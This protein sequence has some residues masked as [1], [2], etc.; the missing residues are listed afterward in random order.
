M[1]DACVIH[2][3]NNSISSNFK[4]QLTLRISLMFL[5]H[6]TTRLHSL[7]ILFLVLLLHITSRLHSLIILL[8]TLLLHYTQITFSCYFVSGYLQTA[9]LHRVPADDI[10][11]GYIS[12]AVTRRGLSLHIHVQNQTR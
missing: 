1:S 3:N 6:I 4:G 7:I 11:R 9:L 12:E 10:V 5:L 2:S 8:L